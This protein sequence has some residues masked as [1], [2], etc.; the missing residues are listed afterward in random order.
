MI[1]IDR[2]IARGRECVCKS[3]G[4]LECVCVCDRGGEKERLYIWERETKLI[5]V[6][7]GKVKEPPRRLDHENRELNCEN[8][9]TVKTKSNTVKTANYCFVFVKVQR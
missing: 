7:Q 8:A 3:E 6:L 1:L 9:K 4:E 5:K 2:W